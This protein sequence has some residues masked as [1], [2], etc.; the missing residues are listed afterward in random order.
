VKVDKAAT[1]VVDES[2]T[3][4]TGAIAGQGFLARPAEGRVGEGRKAVA[5][6]VVIQEWW[7]VVDHIKDVCRRYAAEGFVAVAPDLYHGNSSSR[8]DEAGRLA[9]SLNL[10]SAAREISAAARHVANAYALRGRVAVNGF[11]MGGGLALAAAAQFPGDFDA[12]VPFYG[13]VMGADQPP[14]WSRLTMPVRGHYAVRDPYYPMNRV[15]EF[16]A[17]ARAAG[18]DIVTHEYDADHAFFNSDRPEVYH[19]ASAAVAW[20]RTINFLRTMFG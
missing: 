9:M 11:C 7:G 2:I 3:F 14:D 8:P 17:Q 16:E 13:L 4:G 15:R 5:G 18:V 19:E 1:T 10:L 20:A 12:C 6:V